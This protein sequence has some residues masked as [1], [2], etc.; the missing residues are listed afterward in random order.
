M[1]LF[2]DN[3]FKMP[4]LYCKEAI[5]NKFSSINFN[6][7]FQAHPQW[8]PSYDLKHYAPK[9][10]YIDYKGLISVIEVDKVK[11]L[12]DDFGSILL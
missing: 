12:F 1:K 10:P 11:K 6:N 5:F 8:N 4:A 3:F 2:L 7:G 9:R